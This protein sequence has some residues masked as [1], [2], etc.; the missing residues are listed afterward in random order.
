MSSLDILQVCFEASVGS[1]YRQLSN[2]V[3]FGAMD[4]PSNFVVDYCYTIG[5]SGNYMIALYWN[6]CGP[7]Y[8]INNPS[9]LKEQWPQDRV[10]QRRWHLESK[11]DPGYRVV[12]WESGW[13][14]WNL[15]L[16][17]RFCFSQNMFLS[18]NPKVFFSNGSGP[19]MFLPKDSQQ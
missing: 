4:G 17:F 19:H 11:Q 12:I 9:V 16:L 7:A 2:F 8:H 15:V 6:I 13:Q 14:D 3:F 5:F 1:R 18:E 10:V